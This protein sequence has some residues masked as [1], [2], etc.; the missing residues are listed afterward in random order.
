M[1][2]I[3]DRSGQV[4]TFRNAA[5]LASQITGGLKIRGPQASAETP[6]NT[7]D[8]ARSGK[9]KPQPTTVGVLSLVVEHGTEPASAFRTR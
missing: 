6:N 3:V 2:R 7:R 1:F 5:T 8:L 9:K 4:P